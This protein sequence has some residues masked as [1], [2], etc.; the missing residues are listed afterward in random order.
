MR[1]NFSALRQKFRE[2]RYKSRAT[3]RYTFKSRKIIWPPYWTSILIALNLRLD[4]I[5]EKI[6]NERYRYDHGRF[7]LFDCEMISE[8]EW[9]ILL[10]EDRRFFIHS[11][12]D[13]LPAIA[14]LVKRLLLGRG[15]GGISTIEQ[16]LVRTILD[17]RRRN[18]SRKVREMI[19][20]TRS[21][22]VRRRLTFSGLIS[23]LHTQ[24]NG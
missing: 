13:L 21:A 23:P 18:I 11:G 17:D 3:E 16:Q 5:I 19:F 20:L 14:R 6:D 2:F 8:I 7:S 22:F 9:S 15:I 12:L 4:C 10:L 24:G 1:P